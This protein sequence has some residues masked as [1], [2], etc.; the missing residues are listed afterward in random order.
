MVTHPRTATRAPGLLPLNLP[1]PVA[2]EANAMGLPVAV[3]VRGELRRV[4]A[5]HDCWQI[6]DEWWRTE[7]SRRYFAIEV[8][9]GTRLNVY[10]DLR[11]GAWYR[12]QYT[13]PVRLQVS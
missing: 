5:V 4:E 11:T 3:T 12:Q 10:H 13:P 6:D 8:A 1:Q 9:G 2:V 7:I